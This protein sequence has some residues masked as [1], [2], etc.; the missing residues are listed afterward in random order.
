MLIPLVV[1]S[2]PKFGEIIVTD[3][4]LIQDARLFFNNYF[5]SACELKILSGSDSIRVVFADTY[6][7]VVAVLAASGANIGVSVCGLFGEDQ[8]GKRSI[9]SC[10]LRLEFP[11]RSLDV[12][13]VYFMYEVLQMKH[14]DGKVIDSDFERSKSLLRKYEAWF[15]ENQ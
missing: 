2:S 15:E 5:P 7:F 9:D 1:Q 13:L 12:R 4:E 14:R 10:M 3:E 6:D 8:R 11:E